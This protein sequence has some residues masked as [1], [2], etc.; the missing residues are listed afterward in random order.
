MFNVENM[1]GASVNSLANTRFTGTNIPT[2]KFTVDTQIASDI[3]GH[4]LKLKVITQGYSNEIEMTFTVIL[5]DPCDAATLTFNPVLG[6]VNTYKLY[7][8]TLSLTFSYTDVY[9]DVPSGVNCNTI[10]LN[11]VN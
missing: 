1:A 8:P 2:S 7:H 6:N 11:V 9:S 3:G 5:A 4:P 10:E